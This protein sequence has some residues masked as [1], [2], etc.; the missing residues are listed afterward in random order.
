MAE[1]RFAEANLPEHIQQIADS[2]NLDQSTVPDYTV[3]PLPQTDAER[4]GVLEYFTHH[5]YGE[6]PPVCETLEFQV[7][8]AGSAF[9]G[10]AERRE[11]DIVCGNNGVERVLHMLL[12]LP[13]E[14]NGKVPCF[15]GL[16]FVGNIDTT[17]DPEVT[18][19]PFER[20]HA[21]FAWH[22]DRRADES[23][24]GV[25]AYRWEYEKVLKAGFAAATIC[26]FD[27]FPDHPDG[28]EK[29]IMPMF[30]SAELW[31]SPQ[32]PSS[33]VSAWAWGISRAIDCLLTL[34]EIDGNKII[35]HGL[36]RLGK[37]AIWAGAN[38]PRIAMTVSICSG[39]LGAKLTRR[40]F[41]ENLDWLLFW[42]E[43]WFLPEMQSFRQRDREM[44]VDQHALLS[45]IA[46]R[47]L[48]V[49][50]AE[51]DDYADPTGEKLALLHA[52]K[53][54]SEP[55]K[56]RYFIRPGGHDFTTENWIDLLDF[57]AFMRA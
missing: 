16:N 7:R 54:W 15:F 56:T 49:A 35:V 2:M 10:L 14:R 39:T 45:L 20:Y 5:V 38:D 27:L 44:P 32:R 41:G 26:Y 30:Y 28:F 53:A 37:T 25:H 6:I 55:D 40:H 50:S 1:K 23:G 42:R 36:S 48:Y 19:F 46:P 24:R 57:C 9:D 51:D 12:Y 18:F 3:D 4:A 17:G 34:P 33:A 11:I 29:S 52:S 13:V 31:K 22:N 47:A 43:Y 21:E 8:S